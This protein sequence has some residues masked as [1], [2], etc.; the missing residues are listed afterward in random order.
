MASIQDIGIPGIGSGILHPILP[1][2]FRVIFE[3]NDHSYPDISMQVLATSN[4][5]TRGSVISMRIQDDVTSR[6]AK[7]LLAIKQKD[8]RSF[9]IRIDY[10]D[11]NDGVIRSHTLGGVM[12]VSITFSALDYAGGHQ[13]ETMTLSIPGSH[14][15]DD[16]AESRQ[17]LRVL[18]GANL[19]FAKHEA[20]SGA[21]FMD[22]DFRFQTFHADFPVLS[23]QPTSKE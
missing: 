4:Y 20:G 13:R 17:I 16:D 8:S 1:Y 19:T 14:L 18:K 15:S 11:G 7:A 5:D 6:A 3:D 23:D 21:S 9:R 12:I 22:V 10:L 2:R